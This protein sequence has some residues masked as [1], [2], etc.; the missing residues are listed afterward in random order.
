MND[1]PIVIRLFDLPT[2]ITQPGDYRT[3]DG[4]RVTIREVGEVSLDSTRFNATG[5]VWKM[6]RGKVRPRGYSGWHLSGRAF[7]LAEHPRDIVAA[8]DG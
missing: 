2:L 1:L 7:P 5:S 6:F 4:R 8:W 3:R